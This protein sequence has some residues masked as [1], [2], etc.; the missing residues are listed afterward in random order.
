M[1]TLTK[2]Q[3]ADITDIAGLDP[4]AATGQYSGRGMNGQV[5]VGFIVHDGDDMARLGNAIRLVVGDQAEAMLS[6]TR[7]ASVGDDAIMFM[8]DWQVD[9]ILP[10]DQDDDD[11]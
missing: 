8:P 5:C 1:N 2:A 3:V 7:Q 4:R 6:G 11:A 9:G 10:G